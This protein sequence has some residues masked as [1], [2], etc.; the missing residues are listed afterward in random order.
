M[1]DDLN[2][3]KL[4]VSADYEASQETRQKANEDM[5][6]IG[7]DGGMWEGFLTDTHNSITK[8]ARLEFDITSDFVMRFVGEWTLNR[9]N[10][11]YTQDDKATTE[12]DADLLNGV[13]RADFKDN[14]GQISQDNAVLEVSTCGMAAFQLST[15]FVDEEDPENEDQEIV[16]EPIYNAFNHV[17][18]DENSKRI[19]K[20]DAMRV[21]KLT[22]YT[23]D[24]FES[25]FPDKVKSSAYTPENLNEFNWSTPDVIYVA[26]RYEVK[27]EKEEVEVWQNVIANEVKAFNKEKFELVGDELKASGWEFVRKRKINRQ[28]V[29]KTIFSGEEILE[30][31]QRI[32]GKFLPI[33]PM[34]GFRTFVDNVEYT[35]GFVRKLKDSNRTFN[36]LVSKM[37]ESSATS[38]DTVPILT[39]AQVKGIEN[40]WADNSGAY[41]VIND[42]MDAQGNPIAS[43][44]V[45]YMQPN[46][47]DPN[48]IGAVDIV[49]NFTQR[50]T[51]NAPQDTIDPD[52]SGKAI[53]ALR[54][55]ENLNTQ[56]VSDNIRQS[57]KHSGKVYRSMAGD[58]Y[59]RSQMK[60]VIGIDGKTKMEQLNVQSLDPQTGNPIQL[61]DL[62]RGR[63]SVD[64][65]VGPQYESQKEATID[66]IESVIEKVG[67]DSPYFGALMGVWMENISGTGLESLKKFNRQLMLKQGLV[68][69]ETPE[70][71]QMLQQLQQETDPQEELVKAAANQQNAEANNLEASSIQKL[72]DAQYKKAQAAEK[73]VDIGIKRTEQTLRRLTQIPASAG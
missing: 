42:L 22:A 59:T 4:D 12:E 13:Y 25:E 68:E 45:G 17:M 1:N 46:Q 26:E 11:L 35:R 67:P 21:T 39:R 72:A 19:D 2:Q 63:F 47:V 71:E 73:V 27:T 55:R 31:S 40:E 61:N 64:V 69:P 43:G 51:G 3:Y 14:D 10:V 30:E 20:A 37:A 8:R 28:V 44:P 15:K 50:Q 65:E 18:F 56:V 7:V 34:Y 52:A 6:F 32:A 70:E 60:K 58:T 54:Q 23:H 57:I 5:R 49:S 36:M 66:S 29:Y 41:K 48:T 16:F 33:I 62:S 53:N 24:K 38:G 9:A